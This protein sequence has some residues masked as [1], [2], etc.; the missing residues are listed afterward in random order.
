MYKVSGKYIQCSPV[1]LSTSHRLRINRRTYAGSPPILPLQIPR[2]MD[3]KGGH[4]VD[5]VLVT[6][7]RVNSPTIR[8]TRPWFVAVA[9]EQTTS[10]RIPEDILHHWLLSSFRYL[11]VISSHSHSHAVVRFSTI[12]PVARHFNLIRLNDFKAR[13]GRFAFITAL[14]VRYYAGLLSPIAVKYRHYRA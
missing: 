4:D 9:N 6:K 3:A 7:K 12:R 11:Y 14:T 2:I 13:S 1:I 5:R 8:R 10:V